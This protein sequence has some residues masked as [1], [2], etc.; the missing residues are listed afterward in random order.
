VIEREAEMQDSRGKQQNGRAN[1]G[2]GSDAR[3]PRDEQA[4]GMHGKQ[5]EAQRQG[6]HQE[7]CNEWRE[8]QGWREGV[9][10]I[11]KSIRV[12]WGIRAKEHQ[13]MRLS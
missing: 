5:A 6:R 2:T 9:V 12:S 10:V 7:Q 13:G 8:E 3:R 11:G 1:A 4:A